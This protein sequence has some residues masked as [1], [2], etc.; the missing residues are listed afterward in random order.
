MEKSIKLFACLSLI[1][2]LSFSAL[3]QQ[4]DGIT[5]KRNIQL[6]GSSDTEEIKVEV[7]EDIES[8]QI[9]INS[10][11]QSGYLTMEIYDPKGAKQGNFSV[12]SQLNSNDKKKELVCG[13]M[14]KI[15]KNP[16]KGNW[17]VKLIP[18]KVKGDISI[19]TTQVLQK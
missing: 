12:E 17:I 11:I 3:G 6:D 16:L 18:K 14:Q 9:A 15:I 4:C 1:M 19:C 10:T 8:F 13:Q 7:S 2:F 5:L